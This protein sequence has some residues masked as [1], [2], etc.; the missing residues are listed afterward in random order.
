MRKNKYFFHKRLTNRIATT[1]LLS[2]LSVN[3]AFSQCGL[4]SANAGNDTTICSSDTVPLNGSVTIATGGV[5]FGG[6][7]TFI[8]DSAALQGQY[9]PTVAERTGG[10]TLMYLVTTGN[11]PCAA[12]TDTVIF[13]YGPRPNVNIVGPNA[14]C[15]FENAAYST[16]AHAGSVYNWIP[17]GGTVVAGQGTNIA[18]IK[19][20]AAGAGSLIVIE[21]NSI[22][23]DSADTFAVTINAKPTPVIVGSNPACENQIQGYR[24][25]SI[26]GGSALWSVTGGTILGVNFTDSIT[27]QWG[28]AGAGSVTVT[29]QNNLNCDSTVTVNLAIVP[30]PTPVITG[31]DST[32]EY[33]GG[34]VYS[35]PPDATGSFN[36]VV[37]G[38]SVT[39]GQGTNSATVMWGPAGA[40][41]VAV[42]HT[43]ANNCD[44]TVTFAVVVSPVPNA[45]LTV[46]SPVCASDVKQYTTTLHAG[47][48]YAWTVV[49]GT[50]QSGQGTNS[51]SVL[52]GAAGA[53]AVQL[54]ETNTIGCDT[55]INIPVTILDQNVPVISFTPPVCQTTNGVPFSVVNVPGDTYLWAVTNGTIASGQGTNA[56]TVDFSAPGPATVSITQ[57]N[58]STCD[59]TV[60]ANVT[61]EAKP[62]P[63]ITGSNNLCELDTTQYS[64]PND[65]GSTYNWTVGGGT[66]IA[67]QGTNQIDVKW[68][69]AGAGTVQ[70]QQTN[71]AGCD[72][73]VMMNVTTTAH[74]VP[75][76]VGSATGCEYDTVGYTITGIPGH[77][78][79][80]SVVGG[81][82]V[83]PVNLD[84]VTIKWGP[85]GAATVTVTQTSPNGCDSTVSTNVT[86]NGTPSTP[87]NGPTGVC[88][89]TAGHSYSTSPFG[90]STYNWS[91]TGG[92]ITSNPA[93]HQIVVTWNGQGTGV[94]TVTHTNSAGCD[95]TVSI[96]VS[97]QS[98]PQANVVLTTPICEGKNKTYTTPNHPGN[99]YTW[100]VTGGAIQSGQGTNTIT[101]LWGASG[102]GSLQL[103]EASPANC[104]T[105]ILYNFTIQ[106]SPVVSIPSSP[107]YCANTSN[108]PFTVP[109][110]PGMIYA[111]SVTNGLI[112]QG[113]G[114]NSIEVNWGAAGPATVTLVQVNSFGCDSSETINLTINPSPTPVISGPDSI[115]RYEQGVFSIPATANTINWT[116]TGGNITAG[117]GT[118]Q[119]TVIWGPIAGTVSVT[120]TNAFT[121]ATTVSHNVFAKGKGNPTILSTGPFCENR[122]NP[123]W[124]NPQPGSAF[125]WVVAGGTIING[126]GTD[127]INVNW[128][129]AGPGSVTVTVTDQNCDTTQTLNLTVGSVPAPVISGNT[130]VCAHH[131]EQYSTTND[132]ANTYTWTAT[133]G[134]ITSGNGTN[135][136]TV[137]WGA[138]GAG[139][140]TVT[141]S[142]PG[143][144]DSTVTINVT[145]QPNPATFVTGPSPFCARFVTAYTAANNP[146]DTYNWTVSGGTITSGQGTNQIMVTWGGPGPGSVTLVQSNGTG[147]D[148]TIVLPVYL[149]NAPEPFI[150]GPATPCENS[151]ANIYYSPSVQGVGYTWTVTGGT[152]IAGQGGPS[153]NVAWTT[154]GNGNITLTATDSAGCDTTLQYPV[155]VQPSPTAT[156]SPTDPTACEFLQVPFSAVGAQAGETFEWDFGNGET[157]TN[158][159]FLATYDSIGLHFIEL[160]VTAASGCKDTATTT[161]TIGGGPLA[162]FEVLPKGEINLEKDSIDWINKSSLTTVTWIWDFGNGV[163]QS[164]FDPVY[165]YTE[166]GDYR[167]LLTVTDSV[168]CEDT[169]SVLVNTTVEIIMFVP[170]AFTPNNDGLND[171]FWV[172]SINL[173]E[174]NIRIFN[175]WG[176]M[177]YESNDQN[178]RWDGMVHNKGT[179]QDAYVWHI[180]GRGRNGTEIDRRGTV[181]ILR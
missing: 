44:T 9:I 116:V 102:P 151:S 61:V 40:G 180:R 57:T 8:P 92:T 132:P 60:T 64:T 111:W 68:G 144:C 140:L 54:I 94:V 149:N 163:T 146:G 97:I 117:Q 98:T 20:G 82:I 16:P 30:I 167:V 78:V 28:S 166:P 48:T 110:V 178:F 142:A 147:C 133:G 13:F 159:Q 126:Q 22:G 81:T 89:F 51:I 72:S 50:I 122:T 135:S 84:T 131:Q 107:P 91:V 24:I 56:I 21:T 143:S 27:V 177:V 2:L 36:W 99:T 58:P 38:G 108:I 104:D 152:I 25:A 34:H 42:T 33:T 85:L 137:D 174:F 75:A 179:G 121:C 162:V 46:T 47:D 138:A 114:T 31:P 109:N 39:A 10:Q 172:S 66:I 79:N 141:E 112:V 35:T 176:M 88:E 118:N 160:I 74:P 169:V 175:R 103:V 130:T 1:L 171:E 5:W 55:T 37:T 150:F 165:Q 173:S 53:G 77:S 153:I 158:E 69:L 76:I 148:T 181:T 43:N 164:G 26:P 170:N 95:T 115:C 155:V 73:T 83:G 106:P 29:Q 96:N 62:H 93:P 145:I 70:V 154:P 18:T 113:Q 86:I 124:V 120:E 23:C 125:N 52:W 32:C 168:G 157:S 4:L 7:G 100:T 17:T 136:V 11:G 90:G 127:S 119:I 19:W 45:N 134:L 87:I 128:G 139:T 15:E 14:G 65:P 59:T 80:W 67:G 41:Q 101:V 105:T 156:I 63:L 12:D 3:F 123:Y 129:S 6:L 161:V 49:G 71:A